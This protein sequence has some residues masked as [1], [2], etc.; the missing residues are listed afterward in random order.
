M[1]GS[2]TLE[3]QIAI[4]GSKVHFWVHHPEKSTTIMM[5]HGFRGTH[6]GLQKIIDALPNVRVVIPDLPGFGRSSPLGKRH[7]IRAY[8]DFAV[9]FI[10]RL[11]LRQPILLGHSFGSIVAADLAARHPELIKKLILVNPIADNPDSGSR[12]LAAQSIGL[13]YWLGQKLPKR[14]GENLL[15]NRHLILAS[16]KVMTKTTD[17][18]LKAEIHAAHLRNFGSFADRD[19]LAQVFTASTKANVLQ[20]AN[21]IKLPT[22]LVAGSIDDIA[23]LSAQYALRAQLTDG[24]LTIIDNVGHLV[25]YEAPKQAAASIA[26]FVKN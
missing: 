22:L 4:Q 3:K 24:T 23:P 9:E 5:I 18:K 15:R 12:K 10:Q 20:Y 8:S 13:Y 2:K 11:G 17:E 7:T 19:V 16:S 1:T 14:L 6:M 25:H 21:K 26:Q